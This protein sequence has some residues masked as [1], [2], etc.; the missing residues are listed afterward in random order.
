MRNYAALPSSFGVNSTISEP[1][2][3]TSHTTEFTAPDQIHN[4]VLLQV[5]QKQIYESPTGRRRTLTSASHRTGTKWISY[6]VT[7]AQSLQISKCL[8]RRRR[9]LRHLGAGLFRALEVGQNA[10]VCID[11]CWLNCLLAHLHILVPCAFPQT[12]E[13]RRSL[14]LGVDILHCQLWRVAGLPGLHSTLVLVYTYIVQHHLRHLDRAYPRVCIIVEVHPSFYNLC[15]DSIGCSALVHCQ[16][17]PN[18]APDAKL[19]HHRCQ[20]SG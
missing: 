12:P 11:V 5:F 16:L 10:L 18:G 15:S 20:R 19:G 2:H 4:H 7:K 9:Q 13:V 14:V 1:P 6:K 3:V 17:L 8:S